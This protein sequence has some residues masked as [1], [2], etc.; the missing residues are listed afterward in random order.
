MD[1]K[2]VLKRLEAKVSAK[3]KKLKAQ[4]KAERIAAK[5]CKRR[6]DRERAVR[7]EEGLCK[8]LSRLNRRT[9]SGLTYRIRDNYFANGRD[10]TGFNPETCEA[11][12]YSW[13]SLA[14]RF[15]V[16][17]S[18]GKTVVILN[19][20]HYSSQTSIHIGR[21]GEVMGDLGIKYE[22]L[23]APSGLQN[24]GKAVDY[25]LTCLAERLVRQKYARGPKRKAEYFV[26]QILKFQNR[27]LNLLAKLGYKTTKAMRLAALAYA[28]QSRLD[29]NERQR[30]R[31]ALKRKA[32]AIV[33]VSDFAN[34]LH[35]STDGKHLIRSAGWAWNEDQTI[36]DD[37]RR[38]GRST[39]Q[40]ERESAVRDGIT[41]IYVHSQEPRHLSVVG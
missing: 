32:A 11:H 5:R 26:N 1:T 37:K 14:R 25:E 22:T 4:V 38:R 13:Y 6:D 20:Y 18:G 33:I 8:Q 31:S 16:P 28:E 2:Q 30:E 3:Q 9:I 24:L 23:Q 21:V 36:R 27:E 12:S 10:T 7:H 17:R 40:W 34:K 19:T 39:F 41:K 15:K 29:K 35:G